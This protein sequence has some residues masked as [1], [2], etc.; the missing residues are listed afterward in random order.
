MKKSTAVSTEKE[1]PVIERLEKLSKIQR[2][3]IWAVM[4]ILVIGGFVYFSY[5]DKFE[6]IEKLQKTLKKVEQELITAKKNAQE[7]N[8]YRKEMQA[9]EKEFAVVMR[10]LPEKEEIPLLLTGV[11]KAG[12]DSG[13]KFLLFQPKPEVK[14]D[15]YAEIPVAIKVIGNYHGVGTFFEGVS[16]LNRIV[17]IN[18][19]V[20]SPGK[21]DNLMQTTCTAVTYK[22]IEATDGPTKERKTRKKKR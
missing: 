2:I 12:K 11:S 15:F 8:A 19:I 3:A 22:F 13:L 7:L 20:I 6:K 1:N 16:E 4:L 10:A 21:D 9:K 18:D 5:L 14:K 17:N